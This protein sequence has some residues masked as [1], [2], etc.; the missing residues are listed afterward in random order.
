MSTALGELYR[1][2]IPR[3]PS[4]RTWKSRTDIARDAGDNYLNAEFG[5]RPLIND[6]TNF[7]NAV[8]QSGSILNQYR[9]DEGRVVRR[10]Y[11][12]SDIT[13]V[14]PIQTLSTNQLPDTG[15]WVGPNTP[16][17]DFSGVI[18]GGT[19]TKQSKTVRKRWFS[20]AFMYG[21][22]SGF[23]PDGLDQTV[24]EADKLFGIS[25]TP[26]VLYNLTPWSWAIDWFTN[27]GDVLST[28]SDM[29][30]QGLVVLYGYM[31]EHTIAVDTYTLSGMVYNNHTYPSCSAEVV[32]ETKKRIKA[33]PFGF[34]IT[35]DG[36]SPFQIAI[37]AALGI[38][39]T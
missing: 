24:A 28:L 23:I 16:D 9:R 15:S 39:R 20:G 26:D 32:T 36:F 34:G 22:P 3:R 6:I 8:R 30:T 1:D 2:G 19:W 25:L 35:W 13:T 31:M 21:S 4:I 14:S 37:L 17:L 29:I 12:F 10:R 18:T 38:T 27:T 33:S 7:G 5:W 11:T